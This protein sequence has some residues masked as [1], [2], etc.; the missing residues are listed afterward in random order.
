[1]ALGLVASSASAAPSDPAAVR[2]EWIAPVECP[3]RLDVQQRIHDHLK[4]D[5]SAQL[6]GPIDARVRVDVGDAGLV[7][8]LEVTA[9]SG[10]SVRTLEADRCPAI[11]DATALIVAMAAGATPRLDATP[12]ADDEPPQTAS[13]PKPPVPPVSDTPS[14]APS[15]PPPPPSSPTPSSSAPRRIGAHLQG[16]GG[17]AG[18]GIATVGASLGGGA[19]LRIG[20]WRLDLVGRYWFA[21]RISPPDRDEL[22]ANVRL[23]TLGSRVGPALRWRNF[24]FPLQL[25]VDGGRARARGFGVSTPR[26]S[27]RPWLSVGAFPGALWLPSPRFGVGL[28]AELSTVLVRPRFAIADVGRLPATHSISGGL[29]VQIEWRFR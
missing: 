9:P 11:A 24:E 18:G 22:G 12:E 4:S 17:W 6:Q 5:P 8:R 29:V 2:L 23:W 1:M 13:I 26:A 14:T 19:G 7:A 28:A 21:R 25:G 27:V 16:H 3:S 10:V 20:R 15:T